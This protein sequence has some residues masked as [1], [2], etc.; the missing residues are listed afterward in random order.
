MRPETGGSSRGAAPSREAIRCCP[1]LEPS[2]KAYLP[3][4]QRWGLWSTGCHQPTL[5][6][7]AK[8]MTPE[9]TGIAATLLPASEGHWSRSD[10]G[11]GE[12]RAQHLQLPPTE[13]ARGG[14]GNSEE[15][16]KK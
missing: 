6:L 16:V 14:A 7:P 1:L 3:F 13:P 2:R 12:G 4:L 15:A 10:S 8:W 11:S 9:L 5:P